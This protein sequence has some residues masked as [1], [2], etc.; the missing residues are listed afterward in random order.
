MERLRFRSTSLI[1]LQAEL[2]EVELL[3]EADV[4]HRAKAASRPAARP[5]RAGLGRRRSIPFGLRRLV[6]RLAG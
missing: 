1:D 2:R 4:L 5:P 3:R 6:Q